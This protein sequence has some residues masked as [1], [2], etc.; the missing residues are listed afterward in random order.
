MWIQFS[1]FSQ[2]FLYNLG[3]V[4]TTL[5]LLHSLQVSQLSSRILFTPFKI[6]L[7]LTVTPTSKYSV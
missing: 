5:V 3:K 1:E 2:A 6:S 7:L 4:Q